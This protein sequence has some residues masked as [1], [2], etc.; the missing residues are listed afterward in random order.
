MG[1][2]R[3]EYKI[4]V[5]N[6][7]VKRPFP[8][9]KHRSDDNIKVDL[10]EIRRYGVVRIHLAEGRTQCHETQRQ[11]Y[12]LQTVGEICDQ[13]KHYRHLTESINYFLVLIAF[14][15][16]TR[17]AVLRPLR[18]PARCCLRRDHGFEPTAR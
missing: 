12:A 18:A 11:N 4:V 10:K 8:R 14:T 3:S 16:H 17:T 13:M 1:E 5:I 15:N 7:E 2:M 6:P 9:P